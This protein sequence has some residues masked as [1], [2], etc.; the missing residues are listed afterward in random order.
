MEVHLGFQGCWE[1]VLRAYRSFFYRIQSFLGEEILQ[2][3]IMIKQH[4]RACLKA[5]PIPLLEAVSGNFVCAMV[6][7]FT[8]A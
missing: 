5:F 3:Y 6:K 2:Q 4:Q 1:T 7:A 8:V